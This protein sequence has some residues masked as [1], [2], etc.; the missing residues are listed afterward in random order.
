[1]NARSRSAAFAMLALALGCS[2]TTENPV[3]Q[4]PTGDSFLFTPGQVSSL[5]STGQVVVTANPGNSSLKSLLDSTFQV[6]TAGVTAKR[7]SV[8]TDLT[9]APL[10]FVGIHR[11]VERASGSFSTWNVVGMDDPQALV[12]LIEVSGFAAS[13]TGVAPTSV[14]GAIGTGAV[15]GLFLKVA[16]G[17]TVTIWS[18]NAGT[19]S[20]SSDPATV[21]CPVPNP[22]ANMTCAIETM[23]LHFDITAATGT[24]GAPARSAAIPTDVD[25]P[26]MRLTYTG[27]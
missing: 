4:P 13:G 19:L 6:L 5:D 27:P 25:I 21:A 1:M 8:T 3:P 18:A 16:T 20:F 10:Y 24:N 15:N 17:G 2:S 12:N 23:H 7:V 9:T 22:S 14:S 26:T 11:V